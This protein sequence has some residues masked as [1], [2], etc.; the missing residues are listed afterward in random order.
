MVVSDYFVHLEVPTFYGFVLAAREEI[1]MFLGE[2]NA[3]DG[4]D[5]ACKR[6]FK[7]S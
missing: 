4:I 6:N 7:F 1:G 3:S 5:M 2:F